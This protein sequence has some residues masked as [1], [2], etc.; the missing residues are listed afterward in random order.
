MGRLS[1]T[2]HAAFAF[3][4][5]P[6]TH[7]MAGVLACVL[8]PVAS[9]SASDFPQSQ[10]IRIIVPAPP[11]GPIDVVS[12]IVANEMMKNMR[13]SVIVENRPGARSLI[14]ANAV[15][16]SDPDGHTLLAVDQPGHNAGHDPRAPLRPH[17]DFSPITLIASGPLLMAVRRDPPSTSVADI[18]TR[19]GEAG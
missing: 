15:S 16:R 6:W 2:G 8:M 4:W 9:V 12:R 18:V 13:H 1:H 10:P 3:A 7:R 5:R 14:A 19:E 11:G 17:R